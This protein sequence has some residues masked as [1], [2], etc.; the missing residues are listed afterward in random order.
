MGSEDP[1][2]HA[3]KRANV[4]MGWTSWPDKR[5]FVTPWPEGVE[6]NQAAEI[7]HISDKLGK[8]R[9]TPG[10]LVSEYRK[11]EDAVPEVGSPTFHD[12]LRDHDVDATPTITAPPPPRSPKPV[13]RWLVTVSG[14]GAIVLYLLR[15]N[16][17]VV[18]ILLIA[19]V[20]LLWHPVWNFWW[21]EESRRRQLSATAVMIL[22]VAAFGWIVWPWP[23][24][25][26]PP[27]QQSPLLSVVSINA[28]PIEKT[29]EGLRIFANVYVTTFG[30]TA[31]MQYYWATQILP[32]DSQLNAEMAMATVMDTAI[33][34]AANNAGTP[35]EIAAQGQQHFSVWMIATREQ[36][37]LFNSGK[38]AFY[39]AGVIVGKNNAAEQKVRFCGF[40]LANSHGN[41][42]ICPQYIVSPKL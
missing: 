2:Y 40:N 7:A 23:S 39:F 6:G 1:E 16:P 9:A 13:D 24:S 37:R 26:P 11:L 19:M 35:I 20:G 8:Y 10:S 22:C 18:A 32:V 28:A 29:R 17:I 5:C 33:Q 15:E 3:R 4:L 21:I 38:D 41:V 25:A 42:L 36:A 30:Y 27:L 31:G 12:W 14:V 34:H